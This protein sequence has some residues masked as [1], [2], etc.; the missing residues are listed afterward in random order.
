MTP[1]PKAEGGACKACGVSDG[2]HMNGCP[3]IQ[4]SGGVSST[5]DGFSTTD[6]W[7]AEL[8]AA[9]ARVA[10]LE[11][12]GDALAA[13]ADQADWGRHRSVE[14][15]GKFVDAWR[16]ARSAGKDGGGK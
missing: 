15:L 12:A 5:S 14:R 1:D 9:R 16:A 6:P 4:F 11:A 8:S 2:A 10:E 7:R 3:R 13:A